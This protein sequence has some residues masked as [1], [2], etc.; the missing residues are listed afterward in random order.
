MSTPSKQS[1][2]IKQIEDTKKTPPNL[3]PKAFTGEEDIGSEESVNLVGLRALIKNCK[4][5]LS[6]ELAP[7]PVAFQIIEDGKPITLFTKGNFS[8][9]TGAAKSRK[10]FLVSMFMAAAIKGSLQDKFRCPTTG[11]N[12]L[13]DTEQ[14]RFKTQEV[15]KRI[16]NLSDIIAQDNLEVYSLRTLDPAERLE[17]IEKVLAD[18]PNINFV[19]IDGIIDLDTD[20]ILQAEQAQRIVSKLM[21]WT[22]IFNIHIVCV[23]HFNKT[24]E[25]LAGHIGTFSLRKADAILSVKKS[26][27]DKDVSVVEAV[28]C[29]EK[30]FIPFAFT[31]DPS[32]IPVILKDFVIE[33]KVKTGNA[34]PANKPKATTAE[35]LAQEV[36]DKILGEVFKEETQ[37]CYTDLWRSI[38]YAAQLLGNVSLGDNSAKEFVTYYQHT[39]N[40]T[41]IKDVQKRPIYERLVRST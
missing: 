33:R 24:V 29:R 6:E 12:L 14:S 36:H 17:L 1:L 11:V 32:G 3:N 5:D 19:V 18:T 28:E 25:T 31:V 40:I 35:D 16:C 4:L 10:T 9:V 22:D 15:A 13:F 7:P 41:R 30:E 38:K 27:D 39:G 34:L 8:I 26:K 2:I 23:L 20:P 21:K 37:R